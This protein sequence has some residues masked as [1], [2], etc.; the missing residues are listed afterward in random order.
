MRG[1]STLAPLI[2]AL[3]LATG[4]QEARGQV[5]GAAREV[6][7][8]EIDVSRR[9]A[10]LR[11]GF[12]DQGEL[13]LELSDGMVLL[14]GE[15]IGR[16]QTGAALE[17]AWRAL[18]GEAV[19][20]DDGPLAQRLR[21]WTP[22]ADVAADESAVAARIDGALEAA[23]SGA[24]TMGAAQT[25]AAAGSGRMLNALLDRPEEMLLLARA[26]RGLDLRDIQLHVG[27]DAL[28]AE[29]TTVDGSV[30]VD[31]DLDVDGELD[32][33]AVVVGGTLRMGDE[34]R[35][36]GDVRLA[37]GRII[38]NDGEV[39]GDVTNLGNDADDALEIQR[40][41]LRAQI[42][43]ELAAEMGDGPGMFGPV[44]RVG[45][46]IGDLI[47]LAFV[48]LLV[49]VLGGGL[50]IHFAREELDVVAETA[51][52]SPVQAGMVGLAGAFLIIP[53]WALGAVA[54]VIT[55]VGILAVPFWVVLFPI[56]VALAGALGYLAVAQQVGEWVARRRYSRLDWVRVANPYSTILAGVSVL[57]LPCVAARVLS[58][59]NLL[60]WVSVLLTVLG[61]LATVAAA[62]VGLGA[63]LLSRGG[64]RPEYGVGGTSRHWGAG[65]DDD[66]ASSP[67]PRAAGTDEVV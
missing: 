60:G 42:R 44:R 41:R 17:T 30:V 34:G 43:R 46:A 14:D 57:V 36:T 16:Y 39:F 54:L 40:D 23:L 4:A 19:T 50:A 31:G 8:K 52:R 47:E 15:T 27:E 53:V 49:G 22:P 67:P 59:V 24:L 38:R 20:L 61:V 32:G 6:V 65:W 28:V 58:A 2:V 37:D 12:A 29:G 62:L 10:A 63:V 35:I 25:L 18:L 66:F 11:L 51:R 64:T 33:D 45:G 56:G 5:A 21:A 3:Q 26:L 55:I 7:S 13:E 9:V 48:V 1:A